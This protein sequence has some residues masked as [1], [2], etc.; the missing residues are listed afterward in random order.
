[1]WVDPLTGHNIKLTLDNP[2]NPSKI[3]PHNFIA[4]T[5]P[6]ANYYR[7]YRVDPP[8]NDYGWYK[9]KRTFIDYNHLNINFPEPHNELQKKMIKYGNHVR[10]S[11]KNYAKLS[12][13]KNFGKK[14]RF[15][16]KVFCVAGAVLDALELGLS[17]ADDLNDDDKKLG[18]KAATTAFSIGGRC[19][20]AA[21]GA[22]IGS[23][24][25]G[26]TG[27]A[28]PAMIPVLALVGGIAGSIGGDAFA[29]WV[30]DITYVEE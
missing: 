15:K 24:A 17:V 21:L 7:Y 6:D 30:A 11:D 23:V 26:F 5:S 18:K 8:H 10:L 4:D 3:E 25:G 19:G 20:G 12:N 14:V 1:M 22:K 16:G 27:P 13:L 2:K 28:A 29:K 9:G